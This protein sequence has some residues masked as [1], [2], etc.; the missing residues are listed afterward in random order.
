MLASRTVNW[1]SNMDG[2]IHRCSPAILRALLA[3]H[4]S[5]EGSA[6]YRFGPRGRKACR[7]GAL[8]CSRGHIHCCTPTREI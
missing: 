2:D 1:S 4:P 3:E 5:V 7:L 8:P 6:T